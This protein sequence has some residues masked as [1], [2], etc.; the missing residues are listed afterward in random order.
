MYKRG[1]QRRKRNEERKRERVCVREGTLTL[2]HIYKKER[3][4]EGIHRVIFWEIG[5]RNLVSKKERDCSKERERDTF[6][7]HE[8][9]S[10]R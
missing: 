8:K 7:R 4:R 5:T 3:E 1:R 6:L 10:D 2:I 9:S